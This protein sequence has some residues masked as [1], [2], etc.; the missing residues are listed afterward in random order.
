VV[1][2]GGVFTSPLVSPSFLGSCHPMIPPGPFK[3]KN[4][5]GQHQHLLHLLSTGKLTIPM[6]QVFSFSDEGIRALLRYQQRRK[7]LGKNLVLFGELSTYHGGCSCGG[8]TF[9]V[10][11]RPEASLICHCQ[12][13]QQLLSGLFASF[14]LYPRVTITRGQDLLVS[15]GLASNRCHFFCRVCGKC[16]YFRHPGTESFAVLMMTLEDFPFRPS[17]HIHYDQR[18][19]SFPDQLPKCNGWLE[20]KEGGRELV[21]EALSPAVCVSVL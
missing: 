12:G 1:F 17:S 15:Y 6:D 18:R 14:A 2:S 7:S 4:D 9:K 3:F 20:R 11:G 8:V 10:S 16:L 19:Y 13:C 21:P 5:P